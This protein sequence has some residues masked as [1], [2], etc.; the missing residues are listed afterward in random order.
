MEEDSKF[1]MFGLASH[2]NCECIQE[3]N[4]CKILS[5]GIFVNLIAV[6]QW[7]HSNMY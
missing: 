4:Q 5:E 1:F 6:M 2:A 3:T 7:I